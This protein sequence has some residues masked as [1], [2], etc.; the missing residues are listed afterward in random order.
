MTAKEAEP[1]RATFLSFDSRDRLANIAQDGWRSIVGN[2]VLALKLIEREFSNYSE[3]SDFT[4]TTSAGR[5]IR[6]LSRGTM[7]N[8]GQTH[9][10]SIEPSGADSSLFNMLPKTWWVPGLN[11][12]QGISRFTSSETLTNKALYPPEQAFLAGTTEH[13][14][15]INFIKAGQSIFE[16]VQSNS[17]QV[18]RSYEPE[19]VIQKIKRDQKL[20]TT[21]RVLIPR[22][23]RK[24]GQISTTDGGIVVSTNVAMIEMQNEQ[25]HWLMA[26]WCLSVFAQ[27][28]FEYVCALQEG[29]RKL[30]IGTIGLLRVP[31]FSLINKNHA[32]SLIDYAKK[33]DPLDL[34][35]PSIRELDV[36]WS[37]VLFQERWN[38]VLDEFTSLLQ[39]LSQ[40][41]LA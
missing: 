33:A 23:A 39:A 17:R 19:E 4:I 34:E 12:V 13:Q 14:L 20:T 36:L 1:T 27:T 2:G 25:E 35:N 22:A 5:I 15:L 6:S 11:N 31:N 10:T 41:R 16:E 28:Q 7:G 30:E 40:E 32:E 37:K 29:M 3:L 18:R 8:G 38:N 26:A 21:R 24:I 9:L